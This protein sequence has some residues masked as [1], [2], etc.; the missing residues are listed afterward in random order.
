[1][2]TTKKTPKFILERF[3]F[4]QKELR[5]L[6]SKLK[7]LIHKQNVMY[8]KLWELNLSYNFGTPDEQKIAKLYQYKISFYDDEISVIR[9]KIDKINLLWIEREKKYCDF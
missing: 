1:M 8:N 6:L 2:E 9:K 3:N 4:E 7:D 5:V